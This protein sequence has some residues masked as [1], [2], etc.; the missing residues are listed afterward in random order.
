MEC[1]GWRF[2]HK[3]CVGVGKLFKSGKISTQENEAERKRD[4]REKQPRH[5]C[6]FVC[7]SSIIDALLLYP[8]VHFGREKKIRSR[9]YFHILA[10]LSFFPLYTIIVSFL[11]LRIIGLLTSSLLLYSSRFGIYVFQLSSDD[12]CRTTQSLHRA[13]N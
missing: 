8:Y 9:L 10:L 6:V 12:S 11:S 3:D 4:L 2:D 7:I 13:S 5:S 1:V